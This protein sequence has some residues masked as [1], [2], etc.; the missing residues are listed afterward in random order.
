[1]M[2]GLSARYE[3]VL[4][5]EREIGAAAAYELGVRPIDSDRADLR[6]LWVA[7]GKPGPVHGVLAVH[8]FLGGRSAGRQQW[9]TG[10]RT[11][12]PGAYVTAHGARPDRRLAVRWTRAA[13]APATPR[14][15][16]RDGRVIV[17][18]GAGSPAR[19]WSLSSWAVL[20]ERLESLLGGGSVVWL[21]GE[22]EAGASWSA[23]DDRAFR[24]RGGIRPVDLAALVEVLLRARM[25]V[26]SDTGPTHLAAQLDVPTVA[27]FGP[28]D[29][30]RWAPV[31]QRVAVVAPPRAAPMTWLDPETAF[32]AARHLFDQTG[33]T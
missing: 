31:G 13:L 15:I 16:R 12:F 28:S 6:R 20:T 21:A 4:A 30:M 10:A 22:A 23:E 25:Y 32:G 24:Q 9:L 7:G 17:H 1:M 2:R 27:L 14:P 11:M 29:P 33:S 19:R 5:A 8:A 26:G 18:V 3:V